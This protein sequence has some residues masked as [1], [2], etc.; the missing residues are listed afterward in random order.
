VQL[1]TRASSES[2]VTGSEE[3][4]IDFVQP[5]S[6]GLVRITSRHGA[7]TRVGARSHKWDEVA[8]RCLPGAAPL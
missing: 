2:T 5:Q 4:V 8:R 1:T 7:H 6:I 3:T